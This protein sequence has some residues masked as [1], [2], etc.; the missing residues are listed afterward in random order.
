MTAHRVRQVGPSTF[1]AP[2]LARGAFSRAWRLG[3]ALGT[4]LGLVACLDDSSNT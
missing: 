4:V 3:L 2:S 1:A